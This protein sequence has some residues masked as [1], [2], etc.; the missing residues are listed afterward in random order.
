MINLAQSTGF[1][2]NGFGYVVIDA[3]SF[4]LRTRSDVR[5]S[6]KTFAPNGLL[7]LVQGEGGKSFLSLEL[8]DG[9]LIYQVL[10]FE[11]AFQQI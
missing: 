10:L 8:R 11:G 7:F 6:F 4:S 1:R 9:R 2:F 5:L 3:R